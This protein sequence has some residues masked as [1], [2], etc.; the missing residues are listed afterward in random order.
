MLRGYARGTADEQKTAKGTI[1]Q[2]ARS[3]LIV[4]EV[5]RVGR[6]G[7]GRWHLTLCE[8]WIRIWAIQRPPNLDPRGLDSDQHTSITFQ[9][10]VR[11]YLLCFFP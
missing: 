6:W 1:M 11:I 7:L 4:G 2:G 5:C 8:I 9:Q 3:T 10:L